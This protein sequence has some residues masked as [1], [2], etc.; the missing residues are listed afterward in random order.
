MNFSCQF[1]VVVISVEITGFMVFCDSRLK[2][3]CDVLQTCQ[4][5]HFSTGLASIK[6]LFFF[7]LNVILPVFWLSAASMFSIQRW[8]IVGLESCMV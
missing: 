4:V 6:R 5:I 1:G 2:H 7:L 8:H 3:S